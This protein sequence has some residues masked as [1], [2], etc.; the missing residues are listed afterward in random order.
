MASV[1]ANADQNI[2]SV[3]VGK[4]QYQQ[5]G[6]KSYVTSTD[7]GSLDWQN[8]LNTGSLQLNYLRHLGDGI[9]VGGSIGN[10][11]FVGLTAGV[12]F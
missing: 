5:S 12:G 6:T 10:N 7:S 2:L 11:S 8:T 4:F 9:Y 1:A 3:T